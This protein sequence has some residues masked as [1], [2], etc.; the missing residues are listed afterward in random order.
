MFYIFYDQNN[1]MIITTTN[2]YR[3]II[4]TPRYNEKINK[5][6]ITAPFLN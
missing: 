5:Y 1:I 6:N 2:R 4:F 3:T